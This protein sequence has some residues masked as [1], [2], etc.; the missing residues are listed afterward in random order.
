MFRT[1]QDPLTLKMFWAHLFPI[2]FVFK[3]FSLL[4]FISFSRPGSLLSLWYWPLSPS[5]WSGPP[6]TFLIWIFYY[7][8]I[9]LKFLCYFKMSNIFIIKGIECLAKCLTANS[10]GQMSESPSSSLWPTRNQGLHAWRM[11]KK[12]EH[13]LENYP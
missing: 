4:S 6:A 2:M 13:S 5:H 12:G 11:H 8:F 1:Q 7:K 3:E 10:S 9:I